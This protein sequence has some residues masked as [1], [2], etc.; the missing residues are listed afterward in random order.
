MKTR[1]GTAF[2][3]RKLVKTGATRVLSVG[4]VL[5]PEW[6]IVRITARRTSANIVVLKIQK[7]A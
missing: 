7:L 2:Y 5:P 6:L 1:D 4:K 3:D